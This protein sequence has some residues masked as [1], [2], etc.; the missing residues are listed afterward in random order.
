M[1]VNKEYREHLMLLDELLLEADKSSDDFFS[2]D[3][4]LQK[5]K[6]KFTHNKETFEIADKLY[7]DGLVNKSGGSEGMDITITP[8]GREF[9]ASGGY[10][11]RLIDKEEKEI[12]EKEVTDT[13]I[14]ANRKS[15]KAYHWNIGFTIVNIALTIINLIIVYLAFIRTK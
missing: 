8:K 6:I 4:F 12:K 13:T 15:V 10:I 3:G 2:V 14:E 9:I 5:K 7:E 11:S 1:K